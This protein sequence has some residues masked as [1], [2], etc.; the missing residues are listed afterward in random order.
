MLKKIGVEVHWTDSDEIVYHYHWQ[1]VIFR[2]F[3]FTSSIFVT[4]EVRITP[5]RILRQHYFILLLRLDSLC[6]A[7][8]RYRFLRL[9]FAIEPGMI[10]RLISISPG[11]DRPYPIAELVSQAS[12][13]APRSTPSSRLVDDEF[14]ISLLTTCWARSVKLWRSSKHVF[15]FHEQFRLSRWSIAHV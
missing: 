14:A 11:Q 4:L 1:V 15:T 12:S 6:R 13:R 9:L 5:K 7:Q 8:T 2:V 3:F 10:E